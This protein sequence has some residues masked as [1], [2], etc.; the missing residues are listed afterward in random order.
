MKLTVDAIRDVVVEASWKMVY[1]QS[2]EEFGKLWDQ[3]MQDCADLGA[4]DI[5]SWRLD[6]LNKALETKNSLEA[7]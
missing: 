5:V 2:D 4:E 6:E 3:M 1:A 7:D